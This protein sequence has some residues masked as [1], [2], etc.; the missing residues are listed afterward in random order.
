MRVLNILNGDGRL[1][2]DA[3]CSLISLIMVPDN[4]E[5]QREYKAALRIE[6]AGGL[7]G[8]GRHLTKRDHIL[9]AKF[10][11]RDRIGQLMQTRRIHSVL[12]GAMLWDLHTAAEL[13][14]GVASKNKIE[15]TIDRISIAEKKLG[16]LAT[17][18]SAW[19]RFRPVIHWWA[20][21]AYQTRVF[22]LPFPQRPEVGY[23]GDV[24]IADFLALGQIFL[25][26][27]KDRVDFP[28][29]R[30]PTF[31]TAKAPALPASRA[32]TWPDAHALRPGI[33][34]SR[35]FLATT[36]KYVIEGDRV[37][38]DWLIS[39]PARR[40]GLAQDAKT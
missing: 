34:L 8:G 20:A 21:L 30:P 35:D 37:N 15:F 23:V 6:K 19:R 5:L 39:G 16:S 12:A 29:G 25:T 14:P 31:W 27:A 13:H 10:G 26:F 7:S 18:K 32:P 40:F 17:L 2:W 33:E 1:H 24:V 22:G 11:R 28:E 4:Q 9:A 36:L 3:S 38:R